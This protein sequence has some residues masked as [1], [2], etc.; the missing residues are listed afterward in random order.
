M[1]NRLPQSHTTLHEQL[2]LPL[3]LGGSTRF[4]Q[5]GLTLLWTTFTH[6]MALDEIQLDFMNSIR[7]APEE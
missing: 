2:E 1:P 7:I 6:F 4:W 3:S 5:S